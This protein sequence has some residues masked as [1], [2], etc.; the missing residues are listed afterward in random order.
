MGWTDQSAD[1]DLAFINWR[2]RA[3]GRSLCR[4]S[5]R[6]SGGLRGLLDSSNGRLSSGRLSAAAATI[7]SASTLA[8]GLGNVF[9]RL[10][11]LGRHDSGG[12]KG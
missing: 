1:D 8:T 6:I 5:G 7:V 3:D 10:V 2:G 11:E 12:A 9:K 4:A